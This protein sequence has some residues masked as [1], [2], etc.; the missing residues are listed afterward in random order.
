MDGNDEWIFERNL[1]NSE[2]T[3]S[4]ALYAIV[5]AIVIIIIAIIII[6]ITIVIII[7]VFIIIVVINITDFEPNANN[8]TDIVAPPTTMPS[9]AVIPP[10]PPP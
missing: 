5:N 4:K 3:I 1:I 2:E 9:F 10:A 6:I 7:V 8:S